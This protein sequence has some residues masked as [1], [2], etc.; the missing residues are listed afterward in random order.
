MQVLLLNYYTKRGINYPTGIALKL[1][2]DNQIP[3]LQI[4]AVTCYYMCI[5][6]MISVK[7]VE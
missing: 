2:P 4:K 7:A 6:V 1:N 5:Y 3:I